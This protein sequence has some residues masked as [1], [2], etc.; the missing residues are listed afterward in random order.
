MCWSFWLW[1]YY[2]LFRKASLGFLWQGFSGELD[3]CPL[4]KPFIC[5]LSFSPYSELHFISS[6]LAL[7]LA[8]V[9]DPL[10]LSILI[11]RALLQVCCAP[12][13]LIF[14]VSCENSALWFLCNSVLLYAGCSWCLGCFLPRSWC[15]HVDILNLLPIPDIYASSDRLF[16]S[17][18]AGLCLIARLAQWLAFDWLNKFILNKYLFTDWIKYQEEWGEPQLF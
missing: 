15:N 18:W 6:F 14:R 5:S 9:C 3:I 17:L 8:H 4:I 7:I 16:A 13:T 1:R 12:F 11:S 10:C 2:W